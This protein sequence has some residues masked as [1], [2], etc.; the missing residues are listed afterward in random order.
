MT[1][2]SKKTKNGAAKLSH[3][4]EHIR[5]RQTFLSESLGMTQRWVHREIKEKE[6]VPLEKHIVQENKCNQGT[7]IS[8][9]A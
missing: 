6:S 2:K 5:G 3:C 7:L 1:N 4:S 9:G 8:S